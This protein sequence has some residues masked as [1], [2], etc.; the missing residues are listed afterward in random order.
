[1]ANQQCSTQIVVLLFK[2]FPP[3]FHG[4]FTIIQIM[5]ACVYIHTSYFNL[6][7]KCPKRGKILKV[8]TS[9]SKRVWISFVAPRA[10]WQRA[11]LGLGLWSRFQPSTRCRYINICC[12]SIY[13]MTLWY[14]YVYINM[15]WYYLYMYLYIDTHIYRD[16]IKPREILRLASKYH[17]PVTNLH[18]DLFSQKHVPERSW[19][20]GVVVHK[21]SIITFPCGIFPSAYELYK[22]SFLWGSDGKFPFQPWLGRQD[23]FYARY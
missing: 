11:R 23:Y 5:Y 20:R 17:P 14:I 22:K 7:S 10:A 21:L 2:S 15:I 13:C 16:V 19:R 4:Q 3:N 18:P 6:P 1:M 9:W 8:W 12:I